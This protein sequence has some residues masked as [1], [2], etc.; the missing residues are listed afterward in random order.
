LEIWLEDKWLPEGRARAQFRDILENELSMP[1]RPTLAHMLRR[2]RQIATAAI[3]SDETVKALDTLVDR[4]CEYLPRANEDEKLS[5]EA[6]KN[7][8]FLPALLRGERDGRQF[9]RPA[10]VYQATRASGFDSQVPVIDLNVLRRPSRTRIDFMNLIKMPQVPPIAV[11]VSHLRHCV[12][13][14]A[15]ANG[16]TYDL[17]NEAVANER[18]LESIRGLKDEPYIFDQGTEN[19]LKATEVFWAAPRMGRYWKNASQDM[20]RQNKLHE[21]LGV[22]SSPGPDDHARLMI[23]ICCDPEPDPG[24]QDI[25]E[26]CVV[27]VCRALEA[28]EDGALEAIKRLV[29]EVS[30]IDRGGN[31]VFPADALWIDRTYLAEPFGTDLDAMLVEPPQIDRASLS[32]FYKRVGTAPLSSLALQKL[33]EQPDRLVDVPATTLFRDRSDLLI[34]LAPNE[35][36]RSALRKVVDGLSVALTRDLKVQVELNVAEAPIVS[37]PATAPAFLETGTLHVRGEAM[38]QGVWIAAFRQIFLSIEHHCPQT[39]IKPLATTAALVA[40]SG[41]REEAESAL[42][43]A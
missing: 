4:I 5:V 1:S 20:H 14:G 12:A 31:G 35:M 17:L 24:Y 11:V 16:V 22:R 41:S 13:A 37:I 30:L 7:T 23:E 10:E 25:H 19:Y 9:Y 27:E 8:A 40:M 32:R 21:F 33:A 15:K 42:I 43:A 18:E 28:E 29:D 2:I 26:R 6:L 38:T 39:D 36:A 34:W 3:V